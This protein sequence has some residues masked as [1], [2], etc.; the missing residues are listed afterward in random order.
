VKLKKLKEYEDARYPNKIEEGYET[1]RH[2]NEEYVNFKEPTV[3]ERFN[4]GTFSTSTV[5]EILSPNMFR[6][7]NSIYHWEILE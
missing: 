7:Y 2:I 1:V 6:T 5:Q 3:G 4:V